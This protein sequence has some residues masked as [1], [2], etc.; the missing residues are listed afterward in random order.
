MLKKNYPGK[1]ANAAAAMPAEEYHRFQDL[2]HLNQQAQAKAQQCFENLI[3]VKMKQQQQQQQQQQR[4]QAEASYAYDQ[5]R[6]PVQQ[7]QQQPHR[8]NTIKNALG[9]GGHSHKNRHTA[10]KSNSSNY[11]IHQQ[12]TLNSSKLS[13]SYNRHHSRKNTGSSSNHH[14]RY[15]H[16]QQSSI[17]FSDRYMSPPSSTD[18]KYSNG[19]YKY[20]SDLDHVS[21]FDEEEEEDD[22]DVDNDNDND[23]LY[24]ISSHTSHSSHSLDPYGADADLDG[25]AQDMSPIHS[26]AESVEPDKLYRREQSHKQRQTQK[27]T[28]NLEQQPSRCRDVD[29][30]FAK[31]NRRHPPNI[32]TNIKYYNPGVQLKP[33]TNTSSNNNNL[34]EPLPAGATH[35]FSKKLVAKNLF[36][37]TAKIV[38]VPSLLIT[39]D[40]SSSSAGYDLAPPPMAKSSAAA[41]FFTSSTTTLTSIASAAAANSN[42]NNN[43]NTNIGNGNNNSNGKIAQT[44][45]REFDPLGLGADAVEVIEDNNLP[46]TP[47]A[48][49]SSHFNNSPYYK[50]NGAE[51]KTNGNGNGNGIQLRHSRTTP[52]SLH[53]LFK[54]TGGDEFAPYY[55]K[56]FNHI[57]N[58]STSSTNNLL[59]RSPSEGHLPHASRLS[60]TGAP[61]SPSI[62]ISISISSISTNS[63]N[64]GHNKLD[65]GGGGG[66]GIFSSLTNANTSNLNANNGN[67]LFTPPMLTRDAFTGG[68]QPTSNNKFKAFS[69][70]LK[71]ER[72]QKVN[73][74]LWALKAA[75]QADEKEIE[76]E[77]ATRTNLD[78]CNSKTIT[79]DIREGPNDSSKKHCDA[80]DMFAA[81][82]DTESPH[83]NKNNSK[84]QARSP[85][86][87]GLLGQELFVP[88]PGPTSPVYDDNTINSETNDNSNFSHPDHENFMPPSAS[89]HFHNNSDSTSEYSGKSHYTLP[90]KYDGGFVDASKVPLPQGAHTLNGGQQQQQQQQQQQNKTLTGKPEPAQVHHQKSQNTSRQ[91]AT[92]QPHKHMLQKYNDHQQQPLHSASQKTTKLSISEQT[93]AKEQ[94]RQAQQLQRKMSGKKQK[95]IAELKST[96]KVT[97]QAAP[98]MKIIHHNDENAKFNFPNGINTA[99]TSLKTVVNSSVTSPT[100]SA[101]AGATS[102]TL[103]FNFAN[104]VTSPAASYFACNPFSPSALTPTGGSMQQ[105]QQQHMSQSPYP[106]DQP[107][108]LMHRLNTRSR[109]GHAASRGSRS[110]STTNANNAGANGS[111]GSS[112]HGNYYAAISYNTG[113]DGNAK[114]N[115]TSTGAAPRSRSRSRS[116]SGSRS[117]SNSPTSPYAYASDHNKNKRSS[118]SSNSKKRL[119]D[120]IERVVKNHPRDV[121]ERACREILTLALHR[122]LNTNWQDI[123]GLN[124]IKKSLKESIIY[125]CLRPDLFGGLIEPTQSMLLYGPTGNGKLMIAKAIAKESKC[126]SLI[127][128]AQSLLTFQDSSSSTSGSSFDKNYGEKLIRALFYLAKQ[129]APAVV[130]I[131]DIDLIFAKNAGTLRLKATFLRE[132]SQL[133]ASAASAASAAVDSPL[134]AGTPASTATNTPISED[135]NVCGSA[136]L[137]STSAATSP[138]VLL[139]AATSRPWVIMDEPCLRIFSNK[140]Y[141]PLPDFETRR[142]L[143]KK[144]VM[145]HHTKNGA[146]QQQ[147]QQQQLSNQDQQEQSQQLA[148]CKVTDIDLR[149]LSTMTNGFSSADL[150]KLAKEAA[151]LPIRELGDELMKV[152]KGQQLRGLEMA[153]FKKALTVVLKSID[154][155]TIQRF[156]NW[157]SKFAK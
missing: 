78:I 140:Q 58:Q 84:L 110:N 5:A 70:E 51:A 29:D 52:G 135:F 108:Q 37:P 45:I 89:K 4:S 121:D 39:Q 113:G 55:I 112:Q 21:S 20:R 8:S 123:S 76:K 47:M 132:W 74:E 96:I 131:D 50:N 102:P 2:L 22:D 98:L 88:S 85:Q 136:G 103:A 119:K 152:P 93:L 53:A 151:L 130:F 148:K 120:R 95:K 7:Q 129:L 17:P 144:L 60:S 90:V 153:D 43:N 86:H 122:N 141:V 35:N 92:G 155:A 64:F 9:I 6:S 57:N 11:H 145:I 107:L 27:D 115:A 40:S 3:K 15:L 101:A 100:V 149:I 83:K 150:T 41:S 157:S 81:D 67:A 28:V 71:K 111:S 104:R 87:L 99:Q 68:N 1:F 36:S 126:L 24:S 16:K 61:S 31:P 133:E 62:S 118:S 72:E 54:A 154:I 56:N 69:E 59:T 138:R 77:D 48:E 13:S 147:Q 65:G 116:H 124:A 30:K 14:Y 156:E 97:N 18:S 46:R 10:N 38:T 33:S 134:V 94:Q 82:D 75:I 79:D 114:T 128:S 34:G 142:A 109:R 63:T 66:G 49:I 73:S 127:L 146:N 106:P 105:Q 42:S 139:L 26:Y 117:H 80:E 143:I 137:G 125:P 44:N 23:D 91:L 25:S 32:N 19:K 12:Q